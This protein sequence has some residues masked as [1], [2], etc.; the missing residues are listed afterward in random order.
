MKPRKPLFVVLEG[1]DRVGKSTQAQL[2]ADAFSNMYG[3]QTYLIRF[4]DRTTTI[5]ESLNNYL[6]GKVDIN[7]HAVHLLFTAN[8][9]ERAAEID[10]ALAQGRC[11]VADRYSYSGIVYTASKEH[12][13]P[14]T[15]EW[16]LSSEEG[17]PPPDLI[18]CLLPE[19]IDDLAL[20][21]GFGDERFESACFQT[22]VLCNYR[23]LARS[24]EARKRNGAE[25]VPVWEWVIVGRLSVEEVHKMILQKISD[26][27]PVTRQQP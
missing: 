11:V 5:G 10:E 3:N 2:L 22:R 20:R 14:P 21:G 1:T 12:P 23:R 8:R 9:W 16:C 19:H 6:S 18:L 7:P 15:W 27:N 17:L 4:P 24:I 13:N 26:H 25:R